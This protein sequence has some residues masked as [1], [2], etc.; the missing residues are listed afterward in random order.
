[1]NKGTKWITFKID[2]AKVPLLF[3]ILYSLVPK[4]EICLKYFLDIKSKKQL[5][6]IA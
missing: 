1:M 2:I 6:W 3:Q 5:L 4:I